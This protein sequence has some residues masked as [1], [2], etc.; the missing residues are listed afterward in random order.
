MSNRTFSCNH[1]YH[2]YRPASSSS[3]SQFRDYAY[4]QYYHS[5]PC[6]VVVSQRVWYYYP[7]QQQPYYQH[8]PS[9]LPPQHTQTNLYQYPTDHS[10][11]SCRRF[12]SS[13]RSM[14]IQQTSPVPEPQP[15]EFQES[16]YSVRLLYTKSGFYARGANGQPDIHGFLTIVSNNATDVDI[17]VAWIPEYLIEAKDLETFLQLDGILASEQDFPKVMLHTGQGE[18]MIIPLF[19]IYSLYVCPPSAMQVNEDKGSIIITTCRGD[20]LQPLWYR[21]S[22]SPWPGFDV[23]DIVG[24][25][26]TVQ[27]SPDDEY[28]HLIIR[29]ATNIPDTR[30]QTINNTNNNQQSAAVISGDPVRQALRDARWNVLERISLTAAQVLDHPISKAILPLLPPSIQSLTHNI[31][32]RETMNDYDRATYYLAQWGDEKDNLREHT[33]QDKRDTLICDIPEINMP[34][35]THTRRDPIA[36]EEWVDYFDA[37]GRLR[38][39]EGFILGLIFRGG[40]HPD[41]RIEAWKFLLGIYPWDSTFDER[42]AIRRSKVD[43]YYEIKARWFNELDV[44]ETEE[45]Q[46]EKHRIDKDVHR[47][48]RTISTFE[49][50]DL[51]NPDPNMAVGTNANMEIMKDIL[52]SYNFHN[53]E[54][55]YVQGMS[56]LLAPIYVAM[57][58]EEMAFW[59]FVHFMDRVESNF[60]MDQSGMH[61]QLKTLDSLIRFMDPQ[62]YKRLEETETANL[63]FCFR[64]L[65]VWFKR[66]FEWDDVIRLW[67]VLWTNHLS[68]HMIMFIALGVLDQHRQVILESLNQFDE[69]LKYINE[70]TG[71]IDLEKTLETSEV[72]FYRFERRIKAMDRKRKQLEVKLQERMIW[73]NQE[74]RQ[75]IEQSIKELEIDDRL[76][77]LLKFNNDSSHQPSLVSSLSSLSS[78]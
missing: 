74:E 37:E 65:L 19:D 21:S 38:V 61:G 44:R 35:P 1:D 36:P 6:A 34:P 4:T 3:S 13:R 26:A 45:F 54:L 66:E 27:R 69:I 48:D 33:L 30:E 46:L 31:T 29:P 73:N 71:T 9:P 78:S 53:T 23:L 24:A 47:T 60:Y 75:R 11:N 17:L 14:T 40:L 67:E 55:G 70:L 68:P 20:L 15:A 64:W 72:L 63:F 16:Q 52:V 50:E 25:F 49:G 58:T 51:P 62:L 42:E 2:Q 39:A 8:Q 57:G 76:R 28:T 41:V 10:S 22:S 59:C 18:S 7:Q 32:V 77:S 43:E 5:P 12:P 56:D